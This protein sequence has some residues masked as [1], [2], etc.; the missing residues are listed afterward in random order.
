MCS[1]TRFVVVIVLV[2]IF[3]FF[4]LSLLYRR[5]EEGPFLDNVKEWTKG[6]GVDIILDPVGA[7]YFKMNM[8]AA[9]MDARWVIYAF[10]GGGVVKP[11]EGKGV[12]IATILRKRLNII[13][14][15][16]RSRTPEYKVPHEYLPVF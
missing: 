11:E 7:S 4:S 3:P 15:T 5:A 2:V 16:L 10:M 13:G 8:E 1:L 6:K 9:A 12:N 14:T